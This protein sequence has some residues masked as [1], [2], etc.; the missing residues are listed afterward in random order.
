MDDRSKLKTRNPAELQSGLRVHVSISPLDRLTI[1]RVVLR[2]DSSSLYSFTRPAPPL[3]A[4]P[5][6]PPPRLDRYRFTAPPVIQ[7]SR[8]RGQSPEP[9]PDASA[10]QRPKIERANTLGAADALRAIGNSSWAVETGQGDSEAAPA[11]GARRDGAAAGGSS[12][13]EAGVVVTVSDEEGKTPTLVTEVLR[14]AMC[15][16]CSELLLDARVLP[17]S[18]SF[19]KLCWADHVEEKG[20]T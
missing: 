2:L 9:T 13:G 14:D 4:P 1:A 5:P 11:G 20:T 7:E 10:A 16:L 17:C 3:L 15:G 8:K 6:L 18:H 19:C 12:G